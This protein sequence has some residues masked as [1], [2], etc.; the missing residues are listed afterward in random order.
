MP[1]A[2][3]HPRAV[4][5]RRVA[6]GWRTAKQDAT[7]EPRGATSDYAATVPSHSGQNV[8]RY[9]WLRKVGRVR[10]VALCSGVWI[11][12]S[13]CLKHAVTPSQPTGGSCQ[14][15]RPRSSREGLGRTRQVPIAQRH[16]SDCCGRCSSSV[17]LR[18][19]STAGTPANSAAA[20][21]I[22]RSDS[23]ALMW[24]NKPTL[25]G[26]IVRSST[27]QRYA[28]GCQRSCHCPSPQRRKLP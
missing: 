16:D 20:N 10:I 18:G 3:R 15:T 4:H 6:A 7:A 8:S 11:S 28:D 9:R 17:P 1:A 19:P 26:F 2:S 14:S 22:C 5:C 13:R 27:M 23:A 25:A 12:M 21:P 24:I